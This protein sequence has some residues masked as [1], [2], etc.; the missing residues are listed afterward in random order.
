MEVLVLVA[1]FPSCNACPCVNFQN[2]CSI[3]KIL[4]LQG[5]CDL[6]NVLAR[7]LFEFSGSTN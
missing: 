7:T 2:D 4:R 5:K 3:K 6:G 1:D